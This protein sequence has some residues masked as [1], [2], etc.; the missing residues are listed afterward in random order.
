M[1]DVK[2]SFQL[3]PDTTYGLLTLKLHTTFLGTPLKFMM[4]VKLPS[5]KPPGEGPNAV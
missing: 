4:A 3:S 5:T 2:N 1:C